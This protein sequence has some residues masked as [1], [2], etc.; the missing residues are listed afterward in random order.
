[1]R[2][3]SKQDKLAETAFMFTQAAKQVTVRLAFGF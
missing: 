3:L 2:G 1:M